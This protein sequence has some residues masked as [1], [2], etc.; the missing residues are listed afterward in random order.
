MTP[1]ETTILI[2]G[3]GF[4]LSVIIT[5]G[6]GFRWVGK[7]EAKVTRLEEDRFSDREEREKDRDERSRET[8]DLHVLIDALRGQL[9]LFG[10]TISAA[11]LHAAEHFVPLQHMHV[12]EGKLETFSGRMGKVDAT[13]AEHGAMLKGIQDSVTDIKRS[14]DKR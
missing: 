13:Q 2:A 8:R 12:V 7:L 5:L 9:A 10:D 6:G 11:R 1:G 14:L 3:L 4:A